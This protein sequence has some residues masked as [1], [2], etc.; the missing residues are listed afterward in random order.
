MVCNSDPK[1]QQVAARL[2]RWIS[3]GSD[4]RGSLLHAAPGLLALLAVLIMLSGA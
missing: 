3:I 2:G 1:K 4:W